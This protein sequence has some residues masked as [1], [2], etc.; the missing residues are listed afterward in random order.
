MEISAGE[1][2]RFF[3]YMPRSRTPAQQTAQRS[4]T[5][6]ER[7]IQ[8]KRMEQIHIAFQVRNA[9]LLQLVSDNAA[10][11]LRQIEATPY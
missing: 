3:V 7:F 4:P 2:S 5:P 9:V 11:I 6:N 8:G 1:S 10:R